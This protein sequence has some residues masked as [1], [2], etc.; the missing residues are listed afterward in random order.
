MSEVTDTK[1]EL[2]L[3]DSQSSNYALMKLLADNDS[4]SPIEVDSNEMMN[5]TKMFLVVFARNQLNRIIYLTNFLER[6]ES[7][8]IESVDEVLD[9]EQDAIRKIAMISQAMETLSKCVDNAN[10]VVFQVLKDD[11][12]NNIT[13]NTTNIITGGHLDGINTIHIDNEVTTV[14]QELIETDNL[15]GTGC[16]LSSAIVAYLAKNNDLKTSIL[17]SLD[18]VYEGIKNGNYGTL[19]SKL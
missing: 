9:T 1:K 8:F 6:L 17:K 3:G 10:S 11:K 16:N 19:I 5:K 18:Y 4:T 14:K 12:F 2:K 13:I 15:H 7:K